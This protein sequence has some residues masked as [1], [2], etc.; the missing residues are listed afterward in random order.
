VRPA[1]RVE[2]EKLKKS[3]KKVAPG[4]AKGK[5]VEE[6]LTTKFSRVNLGRVDTVTDET[7]LEVNPKQHRSKTTG[8]SR[9]Q[10]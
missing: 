4:T 10:I 9:P 3:K 7:R 2:M 1:E 6:E 8:V 5:S